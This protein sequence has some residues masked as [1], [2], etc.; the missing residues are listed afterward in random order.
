M[1]FDPAILEELV[2]RIV[3]TANPL[4]IILFGSVVSGR[5][6]ENSDLDVLV[7][8]PDGIH[9]RRTARAVYFALRGLGMAKDI[10]VATESDVKDY[11]DNPSLILYSAL[12]EGRNSM[13]GGLRL[14]RKPKSRYNG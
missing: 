10:I 1:K 7:I 14:G 12:R 9:R 5:M 8:M 13:L 6:D 2:A 11:R 4:R 3:A